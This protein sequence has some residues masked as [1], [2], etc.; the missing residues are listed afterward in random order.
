MPAGSRDPDVLLTWIL[1]TM[2]LVRRKVD[3]WGDEDGSGALGRIFREALL[4]NPLKGW[5]TRDIGEVCGLSH[6]GTHHQMIKLKENG[7]VATE[8]DGK[9]HVHVLRGGSMKTAISLVSVQAKTIL[10]M[11]LSEL[12]EIVLES[13]SR[14]SNPKEGD[15]DFSI[16]ISE[17]RA[18]REGDDSIDALV[19]DLGLKGERAKDG[20]RLARKLICELGSSHYPITILSLAERF[21]ES[22][23]RIQRSIERMRGAGLVE[24]VPMIERISQDIFAGLAR[25]YDGRGEDWLMTRGG[26]GRLEKSL[27]NRLLKEVVSGSL[28]IEKVQEIL[29]PV[30]LEERRVLLN[31][32]GGRMPFGY[33]MAG[34]DGSEVAERVM[35][36]VDR[37]LSRLETVA[38]RLDECLE[39]QS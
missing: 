6:T 31:T 26:L 15:F 1:D 23:S 5:D 11:R 21:A 27:S 14:M 29:D 9:W 38:S 18:R 24:R 36:R 12:S 39:S 7:L 8:V 28:S 30:P 34:K 10:E 2:T 3:D 16:T 37:V 4:T 33:R 32:L 22:R 25:Q 35:R 13:E 17:P 20:D 19:E